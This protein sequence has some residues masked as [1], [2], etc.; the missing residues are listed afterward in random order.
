VTWTCRL[1]PAAPADL[2]TMQPGEMFYA[3][4]IEDRTAR[5]VTH[6]LAPEYLRDWIDIRPPIYVR[7]PGG[8]LWNVDARPAGDRGYGDSGWT[9]TGTA[10]RLTAS[11]SIDTGTYHGWLR[12]G[13][14]SDDCEGRVYP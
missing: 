8:S 2:E 9:I 11:P 3:P 5:Y 4:P 1:L 14:L 7:L 10:P 13:V 12:D 6:V